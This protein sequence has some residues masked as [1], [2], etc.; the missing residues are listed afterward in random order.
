[1]PRFL[2]A[3]PAVGAML[4]V[5][6]VCYA[7]S[8][9]HFHRHVRQ[10]VA[11]TAQHPRWSPGH[12]P[13]RE[14]VCI[15]WGCTC[16]GLSTTYGT[17]PGEWKDAKHVPGAMD[18]WMEYQCDT[19]PGGTHPPTPSPTVPPLCVAW[20]C[21]CQGLSDKLGTY[22]NHWGEARA[23]PGAEDFWGH[24]KCTTLPGGTLPPTPQPPCAP[25]DCTCRG[26][27][28][29]YGT[30]PMHWGYAKRYPVAVSFWM[31]NK[32]NTYPG[33]TRPPTAPPRCEQWGCSCQGMSNAYNTWPW[34]WGT[35]ASVKGAVEFWEENKCNTHKSGQ[36]HLAEGEVMVDGVG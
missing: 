18:F 23:Q 15:P 8:R 21:T 26:L 36:Q 11:V 24:F 17:Y 10:P 7:M 12:G 34:S 5:A 1:M 33:G 30:Y 29:K 3:V 35:A 2:Q 32:C 4:V 13:V 9:R 6:S 22:P 19:Y 28:D 27:S 14:A 20:G 16:Q 31:E 25:W